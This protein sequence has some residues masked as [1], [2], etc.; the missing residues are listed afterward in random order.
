MHIPANQIDLEI[1]LQVADYLEVKV[2]KLII[3]LALDQQLA[4]D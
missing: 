2:K 4:E 1:V 3:I